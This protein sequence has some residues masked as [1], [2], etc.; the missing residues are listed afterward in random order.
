VITSQSCRDD[1]GLI[2]SS[3]ILLHL[4]KCSSIANAYNAQRETIQSF[5]NQLH[6]YL[7]A[8]ISIYIYTKASEII[9]ELVKVTAYGI[10]VDSSQLKLIGLI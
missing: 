2:E 3:I 9:K 8:M 6:K 1:Q 10:M 5:P 7:S 4:E